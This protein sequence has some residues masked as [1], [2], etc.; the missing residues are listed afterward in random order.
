M[1]GGL[2]RAR[3]KTREYTNYRINS[4]Y[5]IIVNVEAT[6]VMLEQHTHCSWRQG[7]IALLLRLNDQR[8]AINGMRLTTYPGSFSA[9]RSS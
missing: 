7:V 4:E 6:T 9:S 2:L 3:H 5:G 1:L 8:K